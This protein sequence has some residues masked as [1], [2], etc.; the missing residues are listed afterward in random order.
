MRLT[1]RVDPAHP[2]FAGHFPG[3][4]IVPG[5]LL[6][7]LARAALTEAGV[8]VAG[9]AAAKFLSPV[10][11]GEDLELSAE[12]GRFELRCGDRLVASGRLAFAA[13]PEALP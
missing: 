13:Q 1:L 12:G 8:A 3:R 7:E 11:P 4:P 10:L 2:A 5:A 9:I 6:L